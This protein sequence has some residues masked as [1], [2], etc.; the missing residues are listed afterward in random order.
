MRNM[1]FMLTTDQMR[2][3]TKSVTRRLGWADLIQGERVM[4]CVKCQGIPKGGKIERIGVIEVISNRAERLDAITQDECAREGFP[5]LTPAQFVA[6]FCGA[7]GCQPDQVVQR[8]GF[9][10]VEEVQHAR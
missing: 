2:A 3:Q 8:I 9:L 5:H 6:M 10:F 4:A 7:T 1:S